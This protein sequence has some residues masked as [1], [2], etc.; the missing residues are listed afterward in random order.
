MLEGDSLI[1]GY[2]PKLSPIPSVSRMSQNN[3]ANSYL[4]FCFPKTHLGIRLFN[5]N[6]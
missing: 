5:K 1:R 2:H 4:F 3:S 6:I